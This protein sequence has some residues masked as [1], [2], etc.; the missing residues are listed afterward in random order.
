MQIMTIPN[1]KINILV[2]LYSLK[3]NHKQNFFDN[4]HR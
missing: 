3:Q 1:V 4:L 2:P